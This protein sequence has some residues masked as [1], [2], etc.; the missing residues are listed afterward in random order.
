MLTKTD[1]PSEVAEYLAVSRGPKW[2]DEIKEALEPDCNQPIN[3]IT[4][5]NEHSALILS[6]SC[7]HK[8][9]IRRDETASKKDQVDRILRTQPAW[10]DV[11][12]A[13]KAKV[14]RVPRRVHP[15]IQKSR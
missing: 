15:A 5:D 13:K 6:L 10:C 2:F 7:G 1:I 14:A 12:A 11:C 4:E 3:L 8:K 9:M